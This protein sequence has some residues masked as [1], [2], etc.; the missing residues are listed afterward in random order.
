LEARDRI[1]RGFFAALLAA[2]SNPG[3]DCKACK[4]LRKIAGLVT[5]EFA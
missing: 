1:S 5:E 4:I 2:S 3:C